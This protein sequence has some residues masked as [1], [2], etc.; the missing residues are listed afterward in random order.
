MLCIVSQPKDVYPIE[1]TK[2]FRGLYHV[3]GTT[4][5]PLYGR[6]AE[7]IDLTKIRNRIISNGVKDVILAFDSTLEGDA[8]AL[9]LKEEMKDWNVLISRPAFGIPLGSPLDYVDPGTL[10]RALL[11]RNRF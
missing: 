6:E 4:F 5:S 2:A 1:E 9:Y 8:T 11:G 7:G 10:T 3:L